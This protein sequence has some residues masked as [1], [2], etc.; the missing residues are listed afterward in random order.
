M[1]SFFALAVA[2]QAAA[3]EST[4]VPTDA[5]ATAADE[6]RDAEIVVTGTNLRGVAPVGSSVI[7]IGQQAMQQTGLATTSDILKTIPQVTSLGPGE[8]TIGTNVNSASINSTRANGVNLRGLG[9]QATLTLLDGRRVPPGGISGQLF[10]ASVIPAIALERIDIVADGA[11]ATYGSDAVAGVANLI[12]RRNF[13]G[14][15][16]SGRYA[17]ANGYNE[18]QVSGVLGRKWATGS[19]TV[20][21]E[22]YYH[23]RLRQED[24]ASLF[25]CNQTSFGGTN[26]CSFNNAPGNV[27]DPVTGIRYGLPGGSG[28]GLTPAQLS[29]TPNYSEAYEGQDLLPETR[30]WGAVARLDQELAPNLR[31][32]A[33][34]F[35][36]KRT[37]EQR[38]GRIDVTAFVPSS[39]PF[40]ISFAPGQ[41]APQ[42][43]EYSFIDDAG[44]ARITGLESSYQ[45]AGGLDWD[46]GGSW[47]VSVQASHSRTEGET[48]TNQ[49][50]NFTLLYAALADPNPATSLNLYGSGGVN[51]AERIRSILGSFRPTG[52]YNMDLVN[53]KLDGELFQIP[54]GPVRVAVGGEFHRDF[55]VNA[56][57]ESISTTSLSQVN[58]LGYAANGRDVR[59]AF[60]EVNF[61]LVGAANGG[62]GLERLEF[63]AAARVDDYSDS[64]S[65]TNPKFGIRYDPFEGLSLHGSYGTSFRAPLLSDVNPASSAVVFYIPNFGPFGNVVQYAGGNANLKPETATTWSLGAKFTPK[66]SG[67]SASLDYFNIRYNNIVETAPFYSPQVFSDPAYA[68]FVILNPTLAQ[69]QAIYALP[70]AGTPTIAAA[71][72]DALVDVR[73]NNAAG[74]K[75]QGLD[76][77]V[78]YQSALGD[79]TLVTGVS[80]TYLL[81]FK[82]ALSPNAPFVDR[83]NEANYPLRFRA[84][85]NIGWG[86]EA[87]NATL[88]VNYSNAYDN[89]IGTIQP[90]QRVSAYTT[91]D[92]TLGYDLSR[93]D[94]VFNGLSV[95]V[96]AINL[97]DKD[98]PFAA[99]GLT[100][101]F[102]STVSNPI[103]RLVAFSVRKRF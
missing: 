83:L 45:I 49:N 33:S 68:P 62:P 75:M 80:G 70:W 58:T 43:V 1:A 12:L 91:V 86:N 79:G 3:Q 2:Q 94:G 32:W 71:D 9:V 13:D 93:L 61:P 39:N 44:P 82:K 47:R 38:G 23:S 55:Y 74:I 72:V 6:Q 27:T 26:N 52:S 95:S 60:A 88:F 10:D 25:P 69:V 73:R 8:A 42:Q 4:T 36:S 14:L 56:S 22:Y 92:L 63:N 66:A 31:A 84:R 89:T 34:G 18:W 87:V 7:T 102:D 17:T 37:L 19:I 67:F 28:V 16:T 77:V 78:N 48:F 57:Y 51:T 90:V 15:E 59:S 96:S 46:V 35:Y 11:S 5:G 99:V 98:P 81:S 29:T 100:Q 41:T 103:G 53:L 65:T 54:G 97:F 64:G 40:Y 20:A 85:G 50:P 24:R 30:R 21:G 76:F 101:V